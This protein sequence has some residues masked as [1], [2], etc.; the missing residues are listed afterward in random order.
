MLPASSL[1]SAA[2]GLRK[3]FLQHI[4]ELDD[5]NYI[6][7]GHPADN[8]KDLDDAEEN[9]LN[10]FFYDVNYD[11]YPADGSIDNP[12]YVRLHCLITAVGHKSKEPESPGSS[13][14][15]DVSKG[16]NELR[17]VG[18]VMRVLHEQ[19]L[20]AI[21][22]AEGNEIAMLQVIPHTMN[23]DN[24]NH[25]WS[26]QTD[27]S[28]RLSVAYEM[29]LAPVP[30]APAV[31][32]SPLVGDSRMVVWGDMSREPGSERDGI[33]S[34]QPQVEYLQVETGVDNWMP[35]ICYVETLG[36]ASK[37]LHYVF[38]VEGDLGTAL[39][40]VIAGKAG[41]KVRMF[42]NVWLKKTDNSIVAW[43]EDIADLET[44]TEKTLATPAGPTDTFS[45]GTIDPDDISTR[46]IF[47]V[48]L[49]DDV[50]AA[51]TRTWQAVL[52]AVH[53]WSHADPIDTSQSITTP[54]K[55]NTVL[56]YGGTA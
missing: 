10:L 41:G 24:L 36:D 38:K 33:I 16:E 54:I 2:Y 37:K 43:K 26:T 51:D 25:I 48:R 56:F 4:D 34:L 30:Q 50:K 52:H 11:G 31:E 21:G 40:M 15:R 7:I 28:Y 9:C 19:P 49:P 20:L 17:L 14:E 45:P 55:S 3:L 23:L 53:E 32:A 5:I 44:P 29:A 13:N 46:S 6:R 18:E 47:Q 39:D 12:F 42:W 22:D 27:I 35:H 8:I 1:S